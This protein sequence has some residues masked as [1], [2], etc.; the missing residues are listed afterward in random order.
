MTDFYDYAQDSAIRQVNQTAHELEAQ[1]GDLN[2]RLAVVE[3]KLKRLTLVSEA[4]FSLLGEQLQLGEAE[5]L[6]RI[7]QVIE[8][9][10]NHVAAK[11]T[12]SSCGRE[13]NLTKPKCIYCGGAIL[14][15]P[16]VSPF[17]L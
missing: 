16:D 4:M 11:F 1:T 15:V 2:Q 10:K 17:V 14:G 13:T 8:Q 7:E 5:L 12:C 6:V 3:Q 9:R